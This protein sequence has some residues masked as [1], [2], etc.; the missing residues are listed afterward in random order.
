MKITDEEYGSTMERLWVLIICIILAI[1]LSSCAT[2]IT[3]G[4][5]ATQLDISDN[6]R[7]KLEA[8]HDTIKYKIYNKKPNAHTKQSGK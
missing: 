4:S 2:P 8:E 1:A 3:D 5:R 6:P 7:Q